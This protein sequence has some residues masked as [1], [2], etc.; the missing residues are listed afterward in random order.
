MLNN[1]RSRKAAMMGK[2]RKTKVS[3][4]K[5]IYGNYRGRVGKE[6]VELGSSHFRACDWL[7]EKLR[8]N[9][10]LELS[11]SSDINKEDLI[12]HMKGWSK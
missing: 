10:E 2:D 12:K 7:A 4:S 3:V 6:W 9:P 5:N 8:H 1:N 11:L